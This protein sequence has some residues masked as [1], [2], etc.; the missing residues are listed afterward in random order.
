MSPFGKRSV[1]MRKIRGGG[2]ISAAP[3][4][5]DKAEIISAL[6]FYIVKC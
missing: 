3:K 6:I 1:Y 4:F 5:E 2:N